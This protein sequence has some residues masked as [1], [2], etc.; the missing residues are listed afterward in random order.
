MIFAHTLKQVICGEKQQTRRLVKANES[1]DVEQQAIIKINS[2]VM[3]KVGKSY[4]VQPNRGKKSVAR[5]LLTDIRR[6][7]IGSI[8]NED[9]IDEGFESRKDFLETWYTIH[10][11]N[12]DLEREVWVFKFELCSV[13]SEEIK[14][15]YD[16]EFTKDKTAD[17]SKDLP[18]P[19][20]EVSGSGMH[21]GDNRERGMGSA[22]PDRLPLLT[23]GSSV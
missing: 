18:C 5:I 6:E 4:A 2:R 14:A 3:Y 10:G 8:T 17:Y 20:T 21:R 22:L 11:Q 1:F 16:K 12:A 19:V 9:A 15:L 7:A 23:T 13:I